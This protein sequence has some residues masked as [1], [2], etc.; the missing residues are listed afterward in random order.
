MGSQKVPGIV[1]LRSNGRE[2]GKAYLTILI[3]DRCARPR[4][5]THINTHTHA[6]V[7][8]RSCHCWRHRRVASFGAFRISAVALNLIF[9]MVVKRDTVRP[10]F[11]VG[12]RQTS[13]G[14][15]PE[16]TV[17]G[18]WEKFAAQQVMCGSVQKPLSLPAT[19]LAASSELHHASPFT[20]KWTATLWPGGTNS[21][22]TKPSILKD[23]GNFLNTP[24]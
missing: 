4:T 19:C 22:C 9:P 16:S 3:V 15:D 1:V 14:A 13:P 8:H 21:W 12:N 2:Y 10:I 5:H 7:L 11:R 17:V 20:Q 18:S 6:H 23:S 24:S